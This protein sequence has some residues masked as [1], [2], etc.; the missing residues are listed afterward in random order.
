MRQ[1]PHQAR[2][3]VTPNR[4][5]CQTSIAT[6]LYH[7]GVVFVDLHL[8]SLPLLTHST[9]SS[10]LLLLYLPPPFPYSLYF[11]TSH[12]LSLTHSL[13]LLLYFP[14]PFPYSLTHSTSSSR[15]LLLY[16]TL[17]HLHFPSNYFPFSTMNIHSHL[18]S[19]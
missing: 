11:F 7:G 4:F 15:S 9:S 16:L 5:G 1:A 18:P 6:R 10:T 13:T 2:D 17:Y 14:P 8:P 12:L 3:L 19:Q